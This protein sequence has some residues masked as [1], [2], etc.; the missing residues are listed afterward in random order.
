MSKITLLL[1]SEKGY[2][3]LKEVLST[4][5]PEIIDFI[6]VASD[7]NVTKDFSKEILDLAQKYKLR[8]FRKNSTYQIKTKYAIAISW[9][10]LITYD[11]DQT[12]LIVFHDSSLPKYRGFAPLVNQLIQKEPTLGVTAFLANKE[13]DKGAIIE[14]QKTGISYPIKIEE[15]I[16]MVT[17][18]Y[19]NIAVSIVGS[20]VKSQELSAIAQNEEQATYSLW[21]DDKDYEINWGHSAED[22]QRFIDAVG[23]PYLGA[24]TKIHERIIRIFDAKVEQDLTIVNRDHGKTL[25]SK[26]NYPVVVCGKGLL[27][28]TQ[29]IY[30][31]TKES[32]F[33]LQ[34]FRLRFS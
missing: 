9:R 5:E 16:R 29:A 11:Q 17:P 7:K 20:I 14:Q 34:K 21:R 23:F 13:F 26:E 28:I 2:A 18:L 30:D 8:T 3:V 6:V 25:F 33:P 22:I 15:A 4:F 27:K 10:W 32:I 31:D 1:M 12:K 24:S 19:N